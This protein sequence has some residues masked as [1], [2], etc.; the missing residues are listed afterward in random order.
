M[1]HLLIMLLFGVMACTT[2]Y[3]RPITFS[4]A[5]YN[6]ENTTANDIIMYIF[7]VGL[8][9]AVLQTIVNSLIAYVAVRT[10]KNLCREMH[11]AYFTGNV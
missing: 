7:V 5:I 3:T 9:Q 4:R 11:K 10:R 8:V 6:F 1:T 2:L